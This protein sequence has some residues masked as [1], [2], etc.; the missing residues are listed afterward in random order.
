MS[1][2][3]FG[4]YDGFYFEELISELSSHPDWNYSDRNPS[5]RA[6]AEEASE[7]MSQ[8]PFDLEHSETDGTLSLHAAHLTSP[9]GAA[10]G[11]LVQ[12]LDYR[13][14]SDPNEG[15][16]ADLLSEAYH[17]VAQDNTTEYLTP[18]SGPVN[19]ATLHV[20]FDYEEELVE[21]SLEAASETSRQIQE[22]NDEL[23]EA[24]EARI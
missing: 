1:D 7:F 13:F 17:S 20:P 10:G 6:V 11:V 24:V 3:N 12:P 21:D 15:S 14:D 18:N 9:A 16:F 8:A 5:E 22:L 2:I 4:A 23:E 19:V